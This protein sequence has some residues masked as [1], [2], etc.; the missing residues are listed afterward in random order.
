M[1]SVS[2]PFAAVFLI[3]LPLGAQASPP[4]AVTPEKMKATLP[5]LEKLAEQ[6]LKRTGVPG[7]A[8]AVV[9]KG[10]VVYLKGFGVREAGKEQPIDA[11]TVFQLASVSK[12]ITS[13]VLAVLVGQKQIDWDDRVIDHDPGFRLCD[14]WATR[15]LRLRDLLCHRSGLPDHAGD[16]LEDM[17]YGRDEILR[18]LRYQRP[19]SSF[20]SEYAYTNFGYTEA[21]V[22]A[23]RAAGESWADL[24]AQTLYHPLGMKS[25]SSRYVD[26]AR[27]AN[28]AKLHVRIDGKWVA[29][30]ER[31]PDAQSPA[32]GVSSTPRDLTRWMRLQL[33]DGKFEGKQLVAEQALAETRRPQMVTGFDPKAGRISSYGLGWIVSNERRGRIFCK[34]SGG[35][36]LGVRTEV[37]LLPSEEV[38]I[39]VL[40]NAAPTGVPEAITESFFDLLLDGGVGRDW[41]EF[42]NRMFEEEVKRELGKETD[43]TKAPARRLPA[44]PFGAYTGT[45]HSSFFG[46]I[47][48]AEDGGS[49]V[50][51]MGPK[52]KS[53]R[54]RPWDRDVFLYQPTGEMAG[55]L[56]GVIFRLGPD[57]KAAGVLVENLN[58]HGQ[59]MF[60]RRATK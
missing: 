39:A 55:G 7:I 15:E 9:H 29:K 21:A 26:F 36:A 47:E 30:Y 13:T 54:L 23:A 12:P 8:I 48:V 32:G 42:A 41:V 35:F 1:T 43:Y 52:K 10:E 49:L 51:R 25:T 6:T 56:A 18:R 4:P 34:H 5:Q 11:D 60:A 28:R 22:A 38:G 19:A 58:V 16:L 2:W 17:G 27:A 20:R 57:R 44:L 14:P 33:A 50:L 46:D 59:G 31:N 40:S 53:Y 45:Y 37:A 3:L 24:A